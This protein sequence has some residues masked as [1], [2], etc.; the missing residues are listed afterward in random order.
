MCTYSSLDDH[1]FEPFSGSGTQIISAQKNGRSCS[2]MDTAPA[3]VDV[4]VRRWQKFAA[5]Q[6]ILDGDGRTFDEIVASRGRAKK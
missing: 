2:A 4:A 3:Y 5:Q 1:V 6:A